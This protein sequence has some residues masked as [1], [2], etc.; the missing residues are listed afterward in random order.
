MKVREEKDIQKFQ[1]SSTYQ[2][3]INDKTL[4]GPGTFEF[5]DGAIYK[6][7]FQK[8]EMHGHG[9][10]EWPSGEY[11]EGEFQHGKRQGQ[12]KYLTGAEEKETEN[13]IGEWHEDFYHGKGVFIW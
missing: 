6:G 4:L 2:G 3:A 13:Y 8:G 12:G 9:A 7:D 5:K 11:Y 10:F 1:E